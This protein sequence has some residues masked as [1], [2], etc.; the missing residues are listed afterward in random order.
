MLNASACR[1]ALHTVKSFGES[2]AILESLVV[3]EA[4]CFECWLSLGERKGRARLGS[5]PLHCN[6]PMSKANMLNL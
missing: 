1:S 5:L 2:L 3:D 4:D 6:R